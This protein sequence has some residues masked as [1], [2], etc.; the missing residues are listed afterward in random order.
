MKK[1]IESFGFLIGLVF[2]TAGGGIIYGCYKLKSQQKTGDIWE[3][4][5]L[6]VNEAY[7]IVGSLFILLGLRYIFGQRKY[8][9]QKKSPVRYNI[10]R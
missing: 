9:G 10:L 6:L 5:F 2:I 4:G 3:Y 1:L 7:C 8:F